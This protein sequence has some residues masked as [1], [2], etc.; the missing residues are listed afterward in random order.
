MSPET[1]KISALTVIA[2][3]AIT[4]ILLSLASAPPQTATTLQAE[5]L[6]ISQAFTKWTIEHGKLYASQ[7]HH[8]RRFNIFK[9]HYQFIKQS[10]SVGNRSYKLGLN[11]DADLSS[12]EFAVKY[13]LKERT[14]MEKEG[15]FTP[16]E[17]YQYS[18]NQV[19]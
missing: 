18:E 15:I 12:E 3:T 5:E 1:K 7:I 10:N 17:E 14:E 2:I 16:V 8:A 11:A 4:T 13:G 9:G 19:G 6:E